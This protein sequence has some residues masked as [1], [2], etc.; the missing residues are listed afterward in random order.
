MLLSCRLLQNLQPVSFYELGLSSS[1]YPR[2][3]ARSLTYR[4]SPYTMFVRQL[5]L[6]SP[7]ISG[8]SRRG[9]HVEFKR[10][11]DI[12]LATHE[13]LGSG[14]YAVVQKVICKSND[15]RPLAQKII[16]DYRTDLEAIMSEVKH[17]QHLRHPHLIQLVGTYALA[18][19]LH[20]LLFPVGQW[21][22]KQFW[23]EFQ[24]VNMNRKAYPEFY[25]LGTFFKCLAYAVAYLHNEITP[26]IKHLDIKPENVI[27][28]RYAA[29]RLTVLLT[30]F[31]VSRSFHPAATSQDVNTLYTTPIYAAPE[32]AHHKP[33]GRPADIFSLGCVFSE[34]ASVLGG[35]TLL[36]YSNQRRC[37]REDGSSTIAF[38]SNLNACNSW[39]QDLRSNVPF[40]QLST[41][42]SAWWTR[43]LE[44]IKD[45][46]SGTASGRPNSI[47]LVN[48][49][50][51][52]PCCDM[53][54]EEYNQQYEQVH[55]DSGM[56]GPKVVVDI[57]SPPVQGP[58]P[59]ASAAALHTIELSPQ[60]QTSTPYIGNVSSSVTTV[61]EIDWSGK[62]AHVGYD[63]NEPVPL[64]QLEVIGL[65]ASSLVT[66]VRSTCRGPYIF[67]KKTLEKRG[68]LLRLEMLQQE[69]KVLQKLHNPHIIRLIGTI[70]EKRF[71]SVLIYPVAE[72][73]LRTFM[74]SISPAE[75]LQ[76]QTP[77]SHTRKLALQKFNKC[78]IQ[79]LHYLHSQHVKHKD[80]KPSNILVQQL[81]T[82]DD[83]HVY[84]AGEWLWSSLPHQ[85]RNNNTQC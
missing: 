54:L 36:E 44:L 77:T 22:L 43:L 14:G 35:R 66:K 48:H 64:E 11:E 60:T 74:E 3:M 53:T 49:F 10:R 52:G 34:M 9:S 62:G 80:I 37:K 76:L 40:R 59:D 83:F 17:I 82:G 23:G 26:H 21:N 15:Q 61:T 19:N 69:V 51:P 8:W 2:K 32:V 46:L 1:P 30:D 81:R 25:S 75:A 47:K 18:W 12:P 20:I 5:G 73:N 27:V 85:S 65:G 78:L 4:E 79:G 24:D 42:D 16:R 68:H 6:N 33:F 55:G 7:E 28:R 63:V 70:D 31:G 72:W 39:L 45:M 50:P 41:G 57:E 84:L 29:H 56:V 13:V 58:P 71:F 38:E 67:A